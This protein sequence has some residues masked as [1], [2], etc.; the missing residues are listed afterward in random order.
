MTQ[1]QTLF[2]VQE[3][4]VRCGVEVDFVEQLV[5]LG[6][7]AVHPT[8]GR[9]FE[10]EVTLRVGKF[11]RIQRDLGVNPDGAALILELLDRM[12]ALEQ[13]LRHLEGR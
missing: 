13:R 6:V 12:E 9:S 11:V 3:V 1:I 7:I 2:S 4:A 5:A 8:G 10:C